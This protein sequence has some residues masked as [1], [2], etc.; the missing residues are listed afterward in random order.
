MTL[1]ISGLITK[2]YKVAVRHV[3]GLVFEQ[4]EKMNY[5]GC[6]RRSIKFDDTWHYDLFYKLTTR[7]FP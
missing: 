3:S 2:W 7:Q 4:K 6:V 5:S 1:T